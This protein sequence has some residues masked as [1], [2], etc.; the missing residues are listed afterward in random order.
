M[1]SDGWLFPEHLHYPLSIARGVFNTSWTFFNQGIQF[2]LGAV[3]RVFIDLKVHFPRY[4]L[5]FLYI[6]FRAECLYLL[7]LEIKDVTEHF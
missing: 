3:H 6:S 5:H 1:S 7:T 4:I 2:P